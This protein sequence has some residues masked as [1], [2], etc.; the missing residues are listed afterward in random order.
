MRIE[1]EI[2][3]SRHKLM[4]EFLFES[5]LQSS[6][7]TLFRRNWEKVDHIGSFRAIALIP[8]CLNF[9][10]RRCI[11]LLCTFAVAFT[12]GAGC[13][14]LLPWKEQV[15]SE[16][17]VQAA[18]GICIIRAPVAREADECVPLSWLWMGSGL[19]QP[20]LLWYLFHR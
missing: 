2:Q 15:T 3:R 11:S 9:F 4:W 20:P 14:V 18:A 5:P 19:I 10:Y 8:S 12:S 16:T 1:S 6:L 13:Y 7:H 17:A